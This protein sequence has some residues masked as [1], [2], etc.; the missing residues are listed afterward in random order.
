MLGQAKQC[1]FHKFHKFISSYISV[2]RQSLLKG[3]KLSS[4]E[5]HFVIL[6]LARIVPSIYLHLVLYEAN[7]LTLKNG[8]GTVNKCKVH[9]HM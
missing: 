9:T 2:F 5:F 3:S 1:N 7:G 8:Y 6:V 4:C